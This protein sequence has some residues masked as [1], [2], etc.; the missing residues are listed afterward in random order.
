M[1]KS[2]QSPQCVITQESGLHFALWQLPW[3]CW[4][5]GMCL[6]WGLPGRSLCGALP[7]RWGE[8]W[9]D[10]DRT[11][12]FSGV[13]Q[14]RSQ[15]PPFRP[16]SSGLCYKHRGHRVLGL[17]HPGDRGTVVIIVPFLLPPLGRKPHIPPSPTAA[18]MDSGKPCPVSSNHCENN[19]SL[20][21]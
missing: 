4:G 21:A 5:V 16:C 8:A 2:L 18:R 12:F 3:S 9:D 11:S 7:Q 10:E 20:V 15:K 1:L 17:P 14:S 19:S 13:S 6:S